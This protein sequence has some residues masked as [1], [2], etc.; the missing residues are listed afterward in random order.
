MDGEI[1]NFIKVWI[2][3]I[4]S[5]CYCYYIVARMI[6]KGM[7]RLLFLLPIF[8]LFTILPCNLNSFHLGGPTAF[9]LGWL[10]NFKLILFAFDQGPLS[11]PPPKLLHFI[12]IACLP[13][14][15]KQDPPLKTKKCDTSPSPSD[16]PIKVPRSSLVV[17]KALIL[18]MIICAYDHRPNLHPYVILTL[19]CCHIYLGVE[20]VLALVAAPARAI[21]G[22]ELEPQFNEPYL[23]TSLQDFWGRRWNLMVTS[24]L[25]PT[26]YIPIR[27]ISINIIGPRW[28]SLP[29][30]I[31]TFVVSGLAHEV[32]YFYFT[33]VHPTWEVTWFFILHGVC[34][35][36]EVLVKKVVTDRW[37]LHRAVSGP[38]TV[39]FVVVTGVWLFFPQIMRNG[40]DL[41]AIE[42]Y[43][44]M[45][46]FV[47]A[48]L[49]LQLLM[50]KS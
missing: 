12:S 39:G 50:G 22:F 2:I 41:K 36:F 45:V 10:G 40:V 11:P 30:I 9:F 35:A 43:S 42:E 18:A 14:K 5:L 24:I 46:D 37:Q 16:N 15:L 21:F 34:M 3:V 28:A 47:K 44:I 38:L 4:T 17:I 31:S 49:P 29:A 26:V 23:A 8:Y 13:I 1:K 27:R 20:I 6:P 48:S 19:Y 33:R 7:M 32:I 25:R